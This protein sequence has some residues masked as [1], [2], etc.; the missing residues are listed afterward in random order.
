METSQRDTFSSV[1]PIFLLSLSAGLFLIFLQ[2]MDLHMDIVT[3]CVGTDFWVD[4]SRGL[5]FFVSPRFVETL[6]F[7][8]INP[9][10][11]FCTK[12]VKFKCLSSRVTTKN[13][14]IV[15]YVLP[16]AFFWPIDRYE[17][18]SFTV[19]FLRHARRTIK[20]Q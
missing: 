1:V 4:S 9:Q 11:Y 20:Y 19:S 7:F 18:H 14:V 2:I 12:P 8:I 10:N 3:M 15:G 16:H 5:G 17:L 13:T 6:V